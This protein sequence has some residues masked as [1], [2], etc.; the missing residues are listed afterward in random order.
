MKWSINMILSN[1]K[2]WNLVIN[3]I[4]LKRDNVSFHNSDNSDIHKCNLEPVNP[5]VGYKYLYNV[6]NRLV[7]KSDKVTSKSC[8]G[9]TMQNINILKV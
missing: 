5:L 2:L 4:K 1:I 7:I 9:V 3:C 6:S 8:N